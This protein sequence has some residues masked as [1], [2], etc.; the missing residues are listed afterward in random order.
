VEYLESGGSGWGSDGGLASP[1]GRHR[2]GKEREE[3]NRGWIEREEE[4][5]KQQAKRAA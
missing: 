3:E 5:S 4:A 1:Q 2:R